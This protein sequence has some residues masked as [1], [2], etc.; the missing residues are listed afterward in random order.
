MQGLARH[1]KAKGM[2]MNSYLIQ[3]VS[4]SPIQGLA[5]HA[6]TKGMPMSSYLIKPMQRITRYPM[7]IEKVGTKKIWKFHHKLPLIAVFMYVGERVCGM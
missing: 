5:R 2:P 1:A 3:I 7:L 4:L 6:K